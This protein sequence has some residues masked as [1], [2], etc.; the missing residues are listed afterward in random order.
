MWYHI[1]C[2]KENKK[3]SILGYEE[4]LYTGNDHEPASRI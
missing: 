3:D 2:R 4:G 1:T